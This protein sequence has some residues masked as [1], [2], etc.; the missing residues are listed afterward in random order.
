[1]PVAVRLIDLDGS[2]V[3]QA[4]LRARV[5]AGKGV[6]VDARDLGDGL[7]IFARRATLDALIA[8]MDATPLPAGKTP[9]TYYGSGDFHHVTAGLISMVHEDITVIHFDNHPDWCAFPPTFNCGGWVCRALAMAHVKR[10]I[11]LGPSGSDLVRPELQFA[12]LAALSEGRLEVYPWRHAPSRVFRSYHDG[13]GHTLRD[14]HLH[15]RN[16]AEEDWPAFLDDLIARL[17]TKAIWLTI[18][19]DVLGPADAVTNWD[20]G[21]MPLDHILTAIDRLARVCRIVGVDVCGDYS[22]PVFG[23]PVRRA[24]AYFDHPAD[25][26]PTPAQRAVN[27]AVNGWLAA[28][29]ERGLAAGKEMS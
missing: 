15:W 29:L 9:I 4:T 3:E 13:P 10:V 1:M 17:P 8:R 28:A 12:D 26:H 25:S 21:A 23:D 18:D 14:G 16:L 2:V 6:R 22:A 19:K 5:D 20:Q 11:T 24:L 7:R 27:G